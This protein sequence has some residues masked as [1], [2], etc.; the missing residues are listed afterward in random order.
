MI[1]ASAIPDSQAKRAQVENEMSKR[2]LE[3]LTRVPT[4]A[5]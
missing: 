2:I 4:I 3:L 5:T 1:Q